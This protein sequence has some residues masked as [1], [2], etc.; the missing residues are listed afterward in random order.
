MTSSG[1]CC[2][3]GGGLTEAALMLTWGQDEVGGSRK[4]KARRDSLEGGRKG[5]KSGAVG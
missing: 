1:V 3:R 2:L 5:A 4:K